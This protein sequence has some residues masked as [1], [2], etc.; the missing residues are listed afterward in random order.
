[1]AVL[2]DGTGKVIGDVSQN[3]GVQNAVDTMDH[4]VQSVPTGVQRLTNSALGILS[5]CTAGLIP[6][7]KISLNSAQDK[8]ILQSL[9]TPGF[10]NASLNPLAKSLT[11]Q[12]GPALNGLLRLLPAGWDKISGIPIQEP[13]SASPLD[14]GQ[15]PVQFANTSNAS[16]SAGPEIA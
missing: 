3:N 16:A 12:G 14:Y 1:M 6:A 15:M 4:A 2:Y 11:S 13:V 9:D 8:G 5:F 10:T 7:Q